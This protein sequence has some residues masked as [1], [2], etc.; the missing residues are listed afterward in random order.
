MTDLGLTNTMVAG[1]I[2]GLTDTLEGETQMFNRVSEDDIDHV[3]PGLRGRLSLE[4]RRDCLSESNVSLSIDVIDRF[5]TPFLIQRERGKGGKIL[6]SICGW[7]PQPLANYF[8]GSTGLL[9]AFSIKTRGL[10]FAGDCLLT[11]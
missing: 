2:L 7:K 11:L 4:R 3:D 10:R 9:G 5:S 1:P 6:S 8:A